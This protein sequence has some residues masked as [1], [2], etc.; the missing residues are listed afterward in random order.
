M[1]ERLMVV[2]KCVRITTS[3]ISKWID[4]LYICC[5]C[6]TKF[7]LLLNDSF[8][9]NVIFYFL[10]HNTQPISLDHSNLFTCLEIGHADDLA[11][12]THT[13]TFAHGNVFLYSISYSCTSHSP[14]LA[15]LINSF[16]SWHFHGNS[17][18]I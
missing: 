17:N 15:H 13:H 8:M 1:N 10:H 6:V 7:S 16:S 5:I 12:Y 3:T 11:I 14:S 2:Y 18:P 9:S 4:L